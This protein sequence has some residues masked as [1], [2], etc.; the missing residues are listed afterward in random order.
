MGEDRLHVLYQSERS[1]RTGLERLGLLYTHG[2]RG[3]ASWSFV[4][5]AGDNVSVHD[6][7]IMGEGNDERL[8]AAW[9]DEGATTMLCSAVTSDAWSIDAPHCVDAPGS[10]MLSLV[11]RDHGV[12]V[13]YDEVTVRGPLVR[14]GLLGSGTGTEQYGLSDVLTNGRLLSASGPQG[15]VLI[16]LTTTTGLLDLHELASL[17]TNSGGGAT[18]G[19]L[20]SLLAPLP[21]DEDMQLVILAGVGVLLAGLAVAIVVTATLGA[22]SRKDDDEAPSPADDDLMLMVT[23]EADVEPELVL[24]PEP[25]VVL[26]E[27]EP[28]IVEEE[29]PHRPEPVNERQERR[30][31]RAM[32]TVEAS[33]DP[34]APAGTAATALPPLPAPLQQQ[35]LPPLPT[36]PPLPA[37]A[38]QA[39]CS[40]CAASF[41]VRD[42]M[43]RHLPCPLC[44]ERVEV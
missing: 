16:G 39:V 14:F 7:Q 11:P 9:I 36:L 2:A 8:V 10:H 30:R 3:E 32:G 15:D 24:D 28:L 38:K 4:A 26:D 42:L 43:L 22:R 12:I 31:R 18:D 37:P 40:S 34:A 5:S 20:A 23:P 41:T 1:D 25:E 35:G 13:V 17:E 27:A 29:E 19:W 21:G 33:P 44:G 6:L